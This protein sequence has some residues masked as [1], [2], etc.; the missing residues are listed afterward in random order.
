MLFHGKSI[1]DYRTRLSR[2]PSVI[3]RLARSKTT[4]YERA[5]SRHGRTSDPS[6]RSRTTLEQSRWGRESTG[7]IRRLRRRM[8]AHSTSRINCSRQKQRWIWANI[9]ST[10]TVIW[11]RDNLRWIWSILRCSCLGYPSKF[12][13]SR[14]GTVWKCRRALKMAAWAWARSSSTFSTQPNSW[15]L[16]LSTSSQSLQATSKT[17]ELCLNSWTESSA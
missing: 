7:W 3:R 13:K 12:S 2:Q 4:W 1:Q 11:R 5:K 9:A 8:M 14:S 15:S 17:T 10:M 16:A 6:P